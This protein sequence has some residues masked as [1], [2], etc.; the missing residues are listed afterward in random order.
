MFVKQEKLAITDTNQKQAK[1]TRKLKNLMTRLINL[2]AR[3]SIVTPIRN[4][5]KTLENSREKENCCIKNRVCWIEFSKSVWRKIV[6]KIILLQKILVK[7]VNLWK[8]VNVIH[9]SVHQDSNL[10]KRKNV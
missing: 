4:V 10:T 6:G 8:V 3:M 1:L 7:K 9:L 5:Q 2:K